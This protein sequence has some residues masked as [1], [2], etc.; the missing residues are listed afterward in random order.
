MNAKNANVKNGKNTS[1]C[2]FCVHSRSFADKN[3]PAFRYR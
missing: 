3:L 1:I 2:F